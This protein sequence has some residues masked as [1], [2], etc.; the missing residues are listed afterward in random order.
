M[1]PPSLRYPQP[2]VETVPVG[3]LPA[4]GRPIAWALGE[5]SVRGAVVSRRAMSLL[6]VHEA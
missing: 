4:A 3:S 1:P 2:E 6:V 5:P